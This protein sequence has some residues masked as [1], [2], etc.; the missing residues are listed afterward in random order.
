MP[1]DSIQFQKLKNS[2]SRKQ[3]LDR[4]IDWQEEG[5]HVKK[6]LTEYDQQ[7]REKICSTCTERQQQKRNCLKLDMYTSNGIQL[8]HC[9]HM[10]RARVKMHKNLIENHIH[11]HPA[12]KTI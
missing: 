1:G 9:N 5:H 4:V 6:I 2:I 7:Y 12:F 8:K 11:L 10:D 3:F